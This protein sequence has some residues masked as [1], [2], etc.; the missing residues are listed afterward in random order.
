MENGIFDRLVRRILV[1]VVLGVLR[2]N[3]IHG[4]LHLTVLYP[5]DDHAAI[6]IRAPVFGVVVPF[7][8][9]RDEVGET[10]ARE[11]ENAASPFPE[12]VFEKRKDS[13]TLTQKEK[14]RIVHLDDED[15]DGVKNLLSVVIAHFV[16]LALHPSLAEGT[17]DIF[18]LTAQAFARSDWTGVAVGLHIPRR[19]HSSSAAPGTL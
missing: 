18:A 19:T 11:A 7:P 17:I 2:G 12:S 8:P 15:D 10:A 13:V 5:C 16:H 9:P 14:P 3:P 1:G 6:R 4:R